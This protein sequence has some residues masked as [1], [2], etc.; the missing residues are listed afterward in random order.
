MGKF[1]IF[2]FSLIIFI[3]TG[4]AAYKGCDGV[5]KSQKQVFPVV[6]EK[7]SAKEKISIGELASKGEKVSFEE[8]LTGGPSQKRP[9]VQGKETDN[10]DSV[11]LEI[12]RLRKEEEA[13]RLQQEKE[14][15]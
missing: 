7:E 3:A 5:D 14:E 6:S 9:K 12:E 11:R 1:N 2:L 10:T 4:V 13:K 15:G 8:A